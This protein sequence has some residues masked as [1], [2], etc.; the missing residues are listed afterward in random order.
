MK[1]QGASTKPKNNEKEEEFQDDVV[2]DIGTMAGGMPSTTTIRRIV[3][4]NDNYIDNNEDSRQ[5]NQHFQ[6]DAIN[7]SG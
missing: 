5:K 6:R 3:V 2:E 4:K 7:V 1:T